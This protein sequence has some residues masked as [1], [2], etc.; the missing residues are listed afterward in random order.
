MSDI[1][2]CMFIFKPLRKGAENIFVTVCT[3]GCPVM[4]NFQLSVNVCI[5]CRVMQMSGDTL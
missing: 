4:H 1:T 5:K 3:L 2:V